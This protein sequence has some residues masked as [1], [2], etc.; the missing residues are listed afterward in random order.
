M[1]NADHAVCLDFNPHD[2]YH[3]TLNLCNLAQ[4]G[5]IQDFWRGGGGSDV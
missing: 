1:L 5:R 2:P 4:Q 3:T